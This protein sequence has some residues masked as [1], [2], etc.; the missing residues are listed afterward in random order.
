MTMIHRR[1]ATVAGGTV[2]MNFITGR[3]GNAGDDTDGVV[4]F[5]KYDTLF[6]MEFQEGF[7]RCGELRLRYNIRI[8]ASF[9]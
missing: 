1:G 3:C 4:C 8:E 7:K 2:N 6:N 9:F 5:F